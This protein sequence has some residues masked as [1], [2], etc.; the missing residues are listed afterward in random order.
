MAKGGY[1]KRDKGG[2]GGS[3]SMS[4]NHGKACGMPGE[5][6]TTKSTGTIVGTRLP[7]GGSPKHRRGKGAGSK[8]MGMDY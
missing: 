7:G 3:G 2:M 8:K 4:Y 5:G 6:S 1:P